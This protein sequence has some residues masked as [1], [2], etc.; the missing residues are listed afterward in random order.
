LAQLETDD[1]RIEVYHDQNGAID[2]HETLDPNVVPTHPTFKRYQDALVD[3]TDALREL[4][5]SD[6]DPVLYRG[7]PDI[8]IEIHDTS[9]SNTELVAVLIGEVKYSSAA[10]TFR[11]GLEELATYRRF[12]RHDGYI[13]DD[14]DVPITSLLIT[15]GYS[16][17]GTGDGITHLNGDELLSDDVEVLRS[18]GTDLLASSPTIGP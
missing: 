15:N 13:V 11:Q 1:R 2:F 9:A 12:A 17:A 14:P 18:F 5:G 4:T 6:Q 7:R 8:V 16:T 3:Y 10:Q